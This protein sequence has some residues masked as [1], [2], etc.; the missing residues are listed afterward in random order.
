[1]IAAILGLTLFDVLA[2]AYGLQIGAITE[3]NPIMAV[4]YD[5]SP[6]LAI[7]AGFAL[8]SVCVYIL[9]Q[10]RKTPLAYY[11]L[12]GVLLIKVYIFGLHIVWLGGA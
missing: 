8:T 10:N 11:G 4:L 7:T 9:W 6:L 2:T 3:G 12:W 1:M 5:I